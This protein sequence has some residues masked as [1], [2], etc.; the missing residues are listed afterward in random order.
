[1]QSNLATTYQELG[2]SESVLRLRKELYTGYLKAFGEEHLKTLLEATNYGLFLRDLRR[3][4]EARSLFRKTLPVARRVLGDNDRLTLK[5]RWFFAEALYEDPDAT[6]DDIREAVTTLED[7]ER[8][9][10]RVMGGAH[11]TTEGLGTCL[12]NA[13]AVLR[14]HETLPSSA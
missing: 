9:A 11:P 3:F 6:L 5:M 13:R 12:R 14:A 1:M 8:I 7:T 4:E 2:R 10:R